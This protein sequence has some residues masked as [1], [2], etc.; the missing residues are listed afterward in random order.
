MA[1]D[2]HVDSFSTP[3]VRQFAG[4]GVVIT[5]GRKRREGFSADPVEIRMTDL[6]QIRALRDALSD[7]IAAMD[8]ARAAAAPSEPELVAP[9]ID[10]DEVLRRDGDEILAA[11]TAAKV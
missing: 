2:F 6:Q 9:V 8:A 5:L 1:Y 7:H 4:S 11:I 10:E 3:Q